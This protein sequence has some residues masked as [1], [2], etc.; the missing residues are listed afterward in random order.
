VLKEHSYN[1]TNFSVAHCGWVEEDSFR[2]S[3]PPLIQDGRYGRHLGFGFRRLE[4][5]RLGQLIR[6]FCCLLGVTRGRFLSMI[7]SAAHPTPLRQ[8]TWMW[9]YSYEPNEDL[10]YFSLQWI[11]MMYYGRGAYLFMGNLLSNRRRCERIDQNT[12]W[13]HFSSVDE[14]PRK[15]SCTFFCIIDPKENIVLQIFHIKN[16]WDIDNFTFNAWLTKS[17]QNKWV[18]LGQESTENRL[19]K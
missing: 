3:A 5:K 9:R 12:S 15:R 1:T 14:A 7:S 2:W 16:R 13:R 18:I 4:D 11:I 10:A 6:I 19:R 17:Y 8:P